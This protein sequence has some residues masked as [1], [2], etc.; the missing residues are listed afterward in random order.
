MESLPFDVEFELR[1]HGAPLRRLAWALVHDAASVDDVLQE[2]WVRAATAVPWRVASSA[3]WL[4]SVVRNAARRLRRAEARRQQREAIV[5]TARGTT[6]E[7]H[8]V[9]LEREELVQ[10]L[11]RALAALDVGYRDA[12]WQRYFE[13]KAPR[14]IA[15]ASGVP[16]ATVK[17]RLQ[18]G[19]GMLRARLGEREGADWRAGFAAAF[20]FNDGAL[21][22]A[23]G[24]VLMATWTK[25]TGAIAAAAA[26]AFFCWPDAAM[27]ASDA[28]TRATADHVVPAAAE[29]DAQ[30]SDT[31]LAGE[32]LPAQRTEAT[33][34]A[35]ASDPKLATIRGRCVD[36]NGDPVAGCKVL[37]R[38][39][40]HSQERETAWLRDHPGPQWTDPPASSTGA[41]GV[42]AFTFWPPPPFQFA[43]ELHRDDL[44]RMRALW[45][46]LA[47]GRVLDVGDVVMVPGIRVQG[48]VVYEGGDP[49]AGAR[50]NV[51]VGSSGDRETPSFRSTGATSERD[52]SFRCEGALPAGRY[53]VQAS[54]GDQY[55]DKE[56][57]LSRDRPVEELVLVLAGN[58]L[59]TITGRIVDEAGQPIPRVRVMGHE[60]I[61]GRVAITHTGR[62]GTFTLKQLSADPLG[63]V[64]LTASHHSL[65]ED[66]RS[67]QAIAWG[68]RDVVV[69]MRATGG[70]E[71]HVSD[72]QQ[73]PIT[74]FTV[75]VVPVTSYRSDD[76][77]VR[78]SPPF[79]NGFAPVPGVGVGKWVVLIEFPTTMQLAPILVPVDKTTNDTMRVDAVAR[80]DVQ[81]TVRVV[82]TDDGPVRGARVQVC[83]QFVGVL[84]RHT[85][86]LPMGRLFYDIILP[87]RALLLSEG[88]TSADGTLVVTGPRQQPLGLCVLCPG[89]V[90]VRIGGVRLDE[91]SPLVVRVAKGARLRGRIGPP[92]AVAELKRLNGARVALRLTDDATPRPRR[93]PATGYEG[94][95]IADD[96]A[97]DIDGLEPGRW[98][99]YSFFDPPLRYG[100]VTLVAGQTTQFDADVSWVLPGTLRGVLHKNGAPVLRTEF[101]FRS[102][103]GGAPF[104]DLSAKTDAEGRFTLQAPAGT[105]GA[106]IKERCKRRGN[107]MEVFLPS[108]ESATVVVGQTTEQAF[109]VWAGA[110]KLTLRDASGAA[111]GG[112]RVR[113]TGAGAQNRNL[114]LPTDANGMI[115]SPLPAENI[116]LHVLPRRLLSF[117]AQQEVG[118][119]IDAFWVPIGTATIVANQTTTLD[120]RL[121]PEFEK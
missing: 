75:R 42:F 86:V 19:L 87:N 78:A 2:S 65:Y 94:Y 95:W 96:G 71:V 6:V 82:D 114:L 107:Y 21:A 25:V 50:I 44:A 67:E 17:S 91:P 62:D 109:H 12:I 102:I 56:V 43:I 58:S 54:C 39:W 74:A 55:L 79:A 66:A 108:A 59:P 90:E 28:S 7:D 29:L 72:E 120:L 121:P 110:L 41:D 5:A 83:L 37:L 36:E 89:C 23:T 27:P 118:Q 106:M 26:V 63:S 69:A 51:N 24:G 31:T 111:V 73:R 70:L 18:R 47:E 49:V 40:I 117:T 46:S 101:Q 20:G 30:R 53:R 3:A 64:V 93:Q 1:R 38:G 103:A 22:L 116:A 113:V 112:V 81:R 92:A 84:D 60:Q 4:A 33:P 88:T 85:W 115:E 45:P 11:M 16:V 48:R 32:A 119:R 34:A 97:F 15:A 61:T 98:I 14:E 13:G 77:R 68:S 100:E 105:Y 8:A 99:V 104:A 9:V 52:G 80:A 57:T 35:T 76:D 10:R